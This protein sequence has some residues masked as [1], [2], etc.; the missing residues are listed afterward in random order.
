MQIRWTDSP[1]VWRCS[2]RD[3][4][5]RV[6][7]GLEQDCYVYRLGF[8]TAWAQKWAQWPDFEGSFTAHACSKLLI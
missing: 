7:P 8:E 1:E 5:L 4:G 2:R 3:D 6:E